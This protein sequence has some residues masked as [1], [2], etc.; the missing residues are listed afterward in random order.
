MKF[1]TYTKTVLTI[2]ALCL[3]WLCVRDVNF[4]PTAQAKAAAEWRELVGYR[5]QWNQG[6]NI[7][8]VMLQP[9][10]G[11]EFSVHVGSLNEL[12]GWAALLNQRPLYQN[13]QGWIYT[14]PEPVGN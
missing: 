3:V 6:R 8:K 11:A 2:I 13:T 5:L 14:G 9:R 4:T 1:D 10:G 12:G 7:G